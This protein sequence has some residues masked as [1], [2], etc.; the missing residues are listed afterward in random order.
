MNDAKDV[1]HK[2]GQVLITPYE[3]LHLSGL[4]LFSAESCSLLGTAAEPLR[5]IRIGS[6]FGTRPQIPGGGVAKEGT[7]CN[8]G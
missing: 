3:L 2:C 7:Y 8:E 1:E 4:T 6:R 5:F